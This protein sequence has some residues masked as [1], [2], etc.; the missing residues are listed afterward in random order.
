[1]R[2]VRGWGHA[3]LARDWRAADGWCAE[4]KNA[5]VVRVWRSLVAAATC[6]RASWSPGF[7]LGFTRAPRCTESHVWAAEGCRGQRGDALA[8]STR[9]VFLPRRDRGCLDARMGRRGGTGRTR[10]TDVRGGWSAVVE[11]GRSEGGKPQGAQVR[12]DPSDPRTRDPARVGVRIVSRFLFACAGCAGGH[13]G[14][15]HGRGVTGKERRG[16][17]RRPQ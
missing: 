6:R 16:W 10:R 3:R 15:A 9:R 13:G 2:L 12:S 1:M 14:Q 17:C 11:H 8:F 5:Q 4:A 7:G